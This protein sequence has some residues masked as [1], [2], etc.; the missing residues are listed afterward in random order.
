LHAE[1]TS[2]SA[3]VPLF[4]IALKWLFNAN[5]FQSFVC[6]SS[7]SSSSND[8]VSTKNVIDEKKLIISLENFYNDAISDLPDDFLLKDFKAY[9][10]YNKTNNLN[11]NNNNKKFI[12]KPFFIAN[13]SFLLSPAAKRRVL[14]IEALVQQHVAQ[15]QAHQHAAMY[16]W[17]SGVNAYFMP[18]FVLFVDREKILQQTLQQIAGF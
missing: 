3:A 18:Y 17:T 2:F 14:N 5:K 15:Q 12:Q 6:S 11:N 13:Y 9:L 4:C 1:S 7:S 8:E 10:H 16:A